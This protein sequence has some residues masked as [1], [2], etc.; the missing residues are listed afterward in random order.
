MKE[1]IQ[2]LNI[3]PYKYI[4]DPLNN[5]LF[6]FYELG[7]IILKPFVKTPI[8]TVKFDKSNILTSS[9]IILNSYFQ[10]IFEKNIKFYSLSELNEIDNNLIEE[11]KCKP[12]SYKKLLNKNIICLE[13]QYLIYYDHSMNIYFASLEYCLNTQSIIISHI[14]EYLNSSFYCLD[15]KIIQNKCKSI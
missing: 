15:S 14:E 11:I 7:Y 9:S 1:I 2:N 8:K 3:I 12:E 6:I 4:I 5:F 13:K 10:L